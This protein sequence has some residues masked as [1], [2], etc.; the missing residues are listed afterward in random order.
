[1]S[2]DFPSRERSFQ[3]RLRLLIKYKVSEWFV[4]WNIPSPSFEGPWRPKD[5][6]VRLVVVYRQRL[7]LNVRLRQPSFSCGFDP[8]PVCLCR[9]IS[10]YLGS[11]WPTSWL[12]K[13]MSVPKERKTTLFSKEWIS[14]VLRTVFRDLRKETVFK[15]EK[16]PILLPGVYESTVIDPSPLR[17]LMT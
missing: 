7:I 13:V 5:M 1:M 2:W 4:L 15:F 11:P 16:N 17:T 10:F 12:S 9:F 14:Y 3:S 6:D 8:F